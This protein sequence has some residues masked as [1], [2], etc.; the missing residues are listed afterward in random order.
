M[1]VAMFVTVKV[2]NIWWLT[3]PGLRSLIGYR[4]T[5]VG[6]WCGILHIEHV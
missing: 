1:C 4:E 2:S 5:S 3:P 6:A